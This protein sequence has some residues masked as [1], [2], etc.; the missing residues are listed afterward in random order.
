MITVK[1]RLLPHAQDLDLPT[2]PDPIEQV[3]LDLVA[4]LPADAPITLAP[5][6]RAA[7][8]TGLVIAL[9][10]GTEAQIRPRAGVALHH[11]VTVLNA[12]G[13]INASY[14]GELHVILVNLGQEPFTVARGARIALLVIAPVAA[15]KTEW[16]LPAEW[17]P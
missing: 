7:I 17:V 9:P 11:G 5:G 4:A 1:M 2:P 14:R 12:P 10:P 16:L 3:G 8:P 6:E 13:T 15:V